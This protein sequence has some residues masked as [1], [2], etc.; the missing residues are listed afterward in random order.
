M[1]YRTLGSTGLAVSAIAFGA[2]PVS[3][4]LTGDCQQAQRETIL[5]AVE[6]GVNWFDT[7]ATYGE[8]RSEES[9]GR[10]FQE[11]GPTATAAVHVATKVRIPVAA[12]HD[13]R[14]FVLDSVALSLKRLQ[15]PAVT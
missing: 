5:R 13:I 10:V 8:G 14:R 6:L 2:G 11:L 9:L 4:L 15:I 1:E 12:L 3:Q 7:A